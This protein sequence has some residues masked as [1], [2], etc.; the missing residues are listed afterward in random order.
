MPKRKSD[1]E[2]ISFVRE[3]GLDG[4]KWELGRHID[5]S[6]RKSVDGG[7]VRAFYED[8]VGL[9]ASTQNDV[10]RVQRRKRKQSDPAPSVH[11]NEIK[12][13][14]SISLPQPT[15]NAKTGTYQFTSRDYTTL[16][17]ASESGDIK[18]VE[19]FVGKGMSVNH[20]DSHGWSALMCASYAGHIEVVNYFIKNDANILLCDKKGR[21]AYDLAKRG[22]RLQIVEIFEGTYT[23][24]CEK[25]THVEHPTF[26]CEICQTDVHN[27]SIS[28]HESSTSHLFKLNLSPKPAMYMIPASNRGFQLMLRSGWDLDRGLGSKGQGAKYPVKTFLKRDRFGLGVPKESRS[29]VTHFNANDKEAIKCPS[30]TERQLRKSTLSKLE[31]SKKER[32]DK[33]KERNFRQ[34][35]NME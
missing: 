10:G 26:H 30:S 14:E 7:E 31:R 18:T 15:S 13:S 21:T 16:L 34:Q 22:K 2:P 32:K 8:L 24:N 25:V 29:K 6:S 27:S 23:E 9:N 33:I 4:D 19:E 17:K 12:N 3:K 28:A 11:Q 20:Q 5:T 35:F 1:F